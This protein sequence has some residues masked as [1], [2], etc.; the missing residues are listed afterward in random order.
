MMEASERIEQQQAA[1]RRTLT[2]LLTVVS[3]VFVGSVAFMVVRGD[4]S[5]PEGRRVL[6]LLPFRVPPSEVGPGPY[7]G[8]AEGLA[9]YFGRADPNDLGVFGLASTSVY[10]ES[11]DDPL[12]AGGTLNA[13][14]SLGWRVLCRVRLLFKQTL[15]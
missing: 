7:S 3:A 11:G 15:W 10:A 2:T 14:L 9:A 6:A 13:D 5:A 1:A 8:F 4:K 12:A